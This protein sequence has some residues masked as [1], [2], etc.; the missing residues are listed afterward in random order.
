[1]ACVYLSN[2]RKPWLEKD[3]TGKG[4]LKGKTEG[5]TMRLQQQMWS[6]EGEA[7]VG[8]QGEQAGWRGWGS[9]LHS[10]VMASRWGGGVRGQL[11]PWAATERLLHAKNH[12]MGR[13]T[14]ECSR[15]KTVLLQS[16]F[17]VSYL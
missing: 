17:L 12:V 16:N 9:R 14:G 15:N 3:L 6:K 11:V 7:E 2:N 13:E 5:G 4:E 8:Q 10:H 1:M